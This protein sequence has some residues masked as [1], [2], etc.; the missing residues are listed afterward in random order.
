M[1]EL[2][3]Q[4]ARLN[5]RFNIPSLEEELGGPPDLELFPKL[6]KPSVVHEEVSQ[7]KEEYVVHRIKVEAVVVRYVQ[8]MDSIQVTV[9]GDLPQ[10][11]LDTLA[12]DL[13]GKLQKLERAPCELIK[14]ERPSD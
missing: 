7:S 10:P 3:K 11:I 9:E 8:G 14:F 6:Y 1:P 4:R 13:L 12:A 2:E 5:K